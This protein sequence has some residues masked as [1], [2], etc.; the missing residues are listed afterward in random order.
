MDNGQCNSEY[1]FHTLK[2]TGTLLRDFIRLLKS[3]R[4]YMRLKDDFNIKNNNIVDKYVPSQNKKG[5]CLGLSK[6]YLLSK[7]I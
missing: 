5:L 6:A 2:R 4:E 1:F 3:D 7:T